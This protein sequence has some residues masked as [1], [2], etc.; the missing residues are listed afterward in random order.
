MMGGMDALK[1]LH[2][3]DKDSMMKLCFYIAD[4]RS[5]KSGDITIAANQAKQRLNSLSKQGKVIVR[6]NHTDFFGDVTDYD[7][8]LRWILERFLEG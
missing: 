3:A 1:S 4:A 2:P 5:G 7:Q 8:P 6:S